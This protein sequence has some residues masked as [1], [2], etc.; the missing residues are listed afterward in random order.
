MIQIHLHVYM[1]NKFGIFCR[2]SGGHLRFYATMISYENTSFQ[3]NLAYSKPFLHP[4]AS[5]SKQEQIRF[6]LDVKPEI[7]KSYSNIICTS[8][9]VVIYKKGPKALPFRKFSGLGK[10]TLPQELQFQKN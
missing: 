3:E 10:E 6:S 4:W 1:L 9:T 2:Y 7:S 8:T 5:G